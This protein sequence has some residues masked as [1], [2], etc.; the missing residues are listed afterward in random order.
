MY[1]VQYNDMNM[2]CV[3][4]REKLIYFPFDLVHGPLIY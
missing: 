1:D 3:M 2:V 4:K